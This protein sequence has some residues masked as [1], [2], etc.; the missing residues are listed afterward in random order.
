MHPFY[1]LVTVGA[2]LSGLTLNWK[3]QKSFEPLSHLILE[4]SKGVGGRMA[5]RRI[6]DSRVDHGAQYIRQKESSAELIDFWKQ[7]GVLKSFPQKDETTFS[8]QEGMTTLAKKLS[9]NLNLVLE[10]QV[11]LLQ[12]ENS[13]W[14]VIS[15][16]KETFW[17]QNV[18]LSCPLPQSLAILEK[19]NLTFPTEMSQISFAQAL[20]GIVEFSSPLDPC[21]DYLEDIDSS[22][23]SIT[24]QSAKGLSGHSIYTVTMGS[25][26]SHQ[27]F[28]LSD[29]ELEDI[30]KN[31]IETKWQ[32]S[33]VSLQV[34]KWRYSHPLKTWSESFCN[35]HPGL[36]LIGDAF[37]APSLNG[38]IQSALGLVDHFQHR[39]LFKVLS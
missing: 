37:Q 16:T 32:K 36:F 2:G 35:P 12:Q 9:K 27:H 33:I 18:I 30:M 23:Y 8:G 13:I 5:T 29:D 17:A 26:W 15:N 34:K 6:G 7:Q 24:S 19:S 39:R 10:T 3:L 1:D 11:T 38:A 28:D 4:K 25:A 14:K 21:W 20:V 22:F 31:L